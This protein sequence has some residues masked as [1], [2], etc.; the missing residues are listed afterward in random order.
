MARECEPEVVCRNCRQ[1]GHMA[2]ECEEGKK[3]HLCGSLDHL[4][5]ECEKNPRSYSAVVARRPGRMSFRSQVEAGFEAMDEREVV[6][7]VA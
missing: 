7:E 5:H 1:K 4:A 2:F 3:C 6:E